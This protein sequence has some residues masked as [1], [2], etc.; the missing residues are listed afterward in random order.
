MMSPVFYG[1][2]PVSISKSLQI[3][4]SKHVCMYGLMR[5]I[6]IDAV[7]NI[8]EKIL[9][10]EEVSIVLH[11]TVP[12]PFN[13]H[14]PRYVTLFEPDSLVYPG[15]AISIWRQWLDGERKKGPSRF[16]GGFQ[17][18][19]QERYDRISNINKWTPDFLDSFTQ[20]EIFIEPANMR[21]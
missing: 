12:V 9:T 2:Y 15:H 21:Y 6:I 19:Y 18:A 8:H 14:P 16:N 1:Q 3:E 17:K 11:E 5:G 20:T 4:Y 7:G 10:T 13:G